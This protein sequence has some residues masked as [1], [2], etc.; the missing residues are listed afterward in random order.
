MHVCMYV[1]MYV[2][3]L[4]CMYVCVYVCMYVCM[5]CIQF[6]VLT[7]SFTH[8]RKAQTLGHSITKFRINIFCTTEATT[9]GVSQ[10]ST[11]KSMKRG[12]MYITSLQSITYT[13]YNCRENLYV[14]SN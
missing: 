2:C 14:A 10:K 12:E 7:D 8:E 6:S 5:V 13:F 9:E 3:M 11:H 1:C 4:V